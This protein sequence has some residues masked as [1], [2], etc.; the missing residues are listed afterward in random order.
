MDFQEFL[1]KLDALYA[2]KGRCTIHIKIHHEAVKTEERERKFFKVFGRRCDEIF[3]E[4][5]VPMWPQLDVHFSSTRFRWGE[6]AV[7]DRRVCAQIFKGMQVQADGDVVPCCVDWKRVNV[8]GN[9][10]SERL[11]AIWHGNRLRALQMS[12]LGGEKSG[13]EPCRGCKMNDYCDLD[14][15]DDHAEECM[16]RLRAR[17]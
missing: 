16:D 15:I 8:L 9:I 3:V 5:L 4:R 6:E 11:A 2:N 17:G 10:R 1:E 14:N 13:L 7:V 12:H